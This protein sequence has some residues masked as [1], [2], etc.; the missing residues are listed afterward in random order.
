MSC[1]GQK[2]QLWQQQTAPAHTAPVSPEPVLENPVRVRYDGI[3]SYLIKGPVT[4]FMYLFAPRDPGLM[5]DG[6]D[7]ALMLARSTR[8]SLA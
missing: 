7:V 4:G 3:D 6:R 8:F 5:V 1:C 2:R